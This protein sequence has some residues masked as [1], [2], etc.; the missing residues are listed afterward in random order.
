M[1][2]RIQKAQII[3][4]AKHAWC[5]PPERNNPEAKRTAKLPLK[6]LNLKYAWATQALEAMRWNTA[7]LGDH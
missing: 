3:V 7:S 6:K 4:Q 1:K 2:S 5:A